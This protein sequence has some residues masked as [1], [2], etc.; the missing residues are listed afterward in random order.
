MHKKRKDFTCTKAHFI[1]DGRY[2]YCWTSRFLSSQ[3]ND[4]LRAPNVLSVVS[5]LNSRKEFYFQ[6]MS[7]VFTFCV[8]V[9]IQNLLF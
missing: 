3:V 8:K 1:R 9:I 2:K 5:L 6:R 4:V 7:Y